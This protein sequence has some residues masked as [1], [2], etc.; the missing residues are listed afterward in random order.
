MNTFIE[1]YYRFK[2]DNIFDFLIWLSD[3]L[4]KNKRLLVASI[5]TLSLLFTIFNF[6]T[7]AIGYI[8]LYGFFFGG[9][10]GDNN[11]SVMET[12]VNPVPFNF[13]SVMIIGYLIVISAFYFYLIG[14]Y[15]IYIKNKTNND[16][17]FEKIM[18]TFWLFLGIMFIFAIIHL[19]MVSF[20]ISG[21]D[22]FKNA[23]SFLYFWI[24]PLMLFILVYWNI[25]GMKYPFPSISG[26]FY[27]FLF[28]ALY[29]K[30]I[31]EIKVDDEIFINFLPF[32]IFAGS[33]VFSLFGNTH[34]NNLLISTILVFPI[35]LL[36]TAFTNYLYFIVIKKQENFTLSTVVEVIYILI[37]IIISIWISYYITRRNNYKADNQDLFSIKSKLFIISYNKLK[38]RI[39]SIAFMIPIFLILIVFIIPKGLFFTSVY[40]REMANF[41][42]DPLVEKEVIYVEE[43]LTKFNDLSNKFPQKGFVVS[44]KNGTYYIVNTQWRLERISNAKILTLPNNVMKVKNNDEE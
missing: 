42:G 36:G 3:L 18:K 24:V 29:S 34:K 14:R 1:I 19:G 39:I 37:S 26:I 12:F 7:F 6:F 11:S 22:I 31:K 17:I 16:K 20:F 32:I 44:E 30:F 10:M 2:S 21:S 40:I 38:D 41:S 13:Y 8:F 28:L 33:I 9:K 4:K 25:R 23:F 15:I 5:T 35:S 27:S 43:S